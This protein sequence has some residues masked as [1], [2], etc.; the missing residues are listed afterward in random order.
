MNNKL[1]GGMFG[2]VEFFKINS[3]PPPFLN[4]KELL[5][6]NAR[7]GINIL[8]TLLRPSKVWMPSFLCDVMVTAVQNIDVEFY[9]VDSHLHVSRDWLNTVQSGELVVFIDYFGFPFD[10]S[11]AKQIKERGGWVL[12]DASQALLSSHVGKNSDFVLFSPRKFLGVPDGGIL[13]N[14]T[15]ID[16]SEVQL[17]SAPAEWWLSAFGATIL[18]REY[19]LY[20]GKRH[21]FNIFQ[22]TDKNGPLGPYAMSELS[23]ILLENS[24]DYSSISQKRRDNYQLLNSYLSEIALFPELAHDV[25]PLGY[26]ICLTNRDYIKRIL[27]ENNVYP[28]VHW[29]IFGIVPKEFEESHKLSNT[30]LTLVC[31]QRYTLSDMEKTAN[32][33][34]RAHSK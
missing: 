31:D 16:F 17:T 11:L 27:F 2:L 7:S 8:S 23:R 24:F 10:P 20:G 1:I 26:P 12:E 4:K 5:L 15:S 33:I 25:V 29:P 6:T 14:N 9:D 22:E 18:R 3:Q 21:W 28:P 34:L 30:I 13:R 19:D 32:I